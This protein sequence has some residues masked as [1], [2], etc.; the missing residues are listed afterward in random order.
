M[1]E[2]SIKETKDVK[3]NNQEEEKKARKEEFDSI[4]E[5]IKKMSEAIQ[6]H[7]NVKDAVSKE[8]VDNNYLKYIENSLED[9]LF[10]D[11]KFD[12]IKSKVL[13]EVV[14][15]DLVN[16]E[17]FEIEKLE[18]ED[19]GS[20]FEELENYIDK[21]CTYD[22]K[23]V[24]LFGINENNPEK[25]IKYEPRKF[26]RLDM[27]EAICAMLEEG[28]TAQ[29]EQYDE[30]YIV[31]NETGLKVFSE[32]KIVSLVK[33]EETVFDKIKSKLSSLFTINMFNKKKCLPNIKLVY[34][35]N[36]N[37]FENFEHNSKI[38]AKS[39]MKALLRKERE[40]TRNTS[41]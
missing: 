29:M 25:V 41:I 15:P 21:I 38:D 23:F 1:N 32:R 19:I 4:L 34:D 26:S 22:N 2:E 10:N 24:C 35:T 9:K 39:R 18:I 33:V 20:H 7:T 31:T 28:K 3:L 36:Q 17:N 11:A 5:K 30:Y 27:I 13:L 14:C 40:V 12:K 16:I 6:L 37:R 8:E